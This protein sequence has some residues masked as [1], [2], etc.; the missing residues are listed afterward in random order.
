MGMYC[1]E[2]VRDDMGLT[3]VKLM[4]PFVRTPDEGRRVIVIMNEM[5][6]VQG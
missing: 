1:T 4:I 5:G 3:N 6:L 2:K